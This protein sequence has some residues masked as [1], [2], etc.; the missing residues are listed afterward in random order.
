MKSAVIF[1]LSLLV[2]LSVTSCKKSVQYSA[3]G[4]YLVVG[5]AG[6]FISG[7]Q[8]THYF[9][10]SGGQVREDLNVNSGMVPD[11]INQFNFNTVLPAAKYNAVK[12]LLSAIPSE[13][14]T[15][16]NQ[17]IGAPIPDMGYIDVR[18]S[19]KGV[20]YRWT[21]EGDQ[22]GTSAAIQQFLDSVQTDFQ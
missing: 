19:I 7:S 18:A 3:S 2:V 8:P 21:F 12:G 11:N 9:I 4:E 22:S 16:N 20:S 13:L 14:L 1:C 6:G 15:R 5:S 10:V 17:D